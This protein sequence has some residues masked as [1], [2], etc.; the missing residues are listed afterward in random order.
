[1]SLEKINSIDC[2]LKII[3][4]NLRCIDDGIAN[5]IEN[6]SKRLEQLINNY[7]PD[8]LSTQEVSRKWHEALI[9]TYSSK[10]YLI[11]ISRLGNILESYENSD[12]SN[13]ILI[14]K[15]RFNILKEETFWLSETPNIVSKYSDSKY[16]R[17]CTYTLVYDKL[18][19][20]G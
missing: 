14:S 13:L 20:I 9:H 15:E 2:N 4:Q 3:T 19:N 17:I 6:R 12:E 16:H 1:M 7:K 18:I 8:I 11:G 10:Y 5:S